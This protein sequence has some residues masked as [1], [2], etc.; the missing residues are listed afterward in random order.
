MWSNFFFAQ[1]CL[2]IGTGS[3]VSDVAHGPLISVDTLI[4]RKNIRFISYLIFIAFQAIKPEILT[5]F[6]LLTSQKFLVDAKITS[7]RTRVTALL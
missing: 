5:H 4:S 3:Q 1:M 2:L 7:I 6:K